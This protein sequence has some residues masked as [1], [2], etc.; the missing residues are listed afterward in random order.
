MPPEQDAANW[1]TKL[2]FEAY[3]AQTLSIDPIEL[4]IS[5][6]A[7][8]ERKCSFVQHFNIFSGYENNYETSV[9]LFLCGENEFAGKG[10]VK[11]VKAIRGT[12]YI[13]SVRLLKRIN[14]FEVGQAAFTDD[15]MKLWSTYLNS[16]SL[17]DNSAAHPCPAT[18]QPQ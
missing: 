7:E 5:E 13:Y 4:L 17:C 2:S 16:I 11:L 10:E 8:D 14:P 9:R 1:E 18:G 3:S 15:D 6:A 12:E